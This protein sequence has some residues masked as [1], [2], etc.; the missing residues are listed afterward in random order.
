V[1]DRPGIATRQGK[2]LPGSAE[3]S[4]SYRAGVLGILV[5]AYTFNFID[6]TIIY[7]IGQA[8]K[9]D[10]ALSDTQLGLLGGL[11][12]ALF[13]TVLGIPIARLADRYNRVNI[14]A[15]SV[16]VWSLFTAGC[17]LAVN[18]MQLL[19]LRMGVGIG[20]AGL[21]PPAHSLISDYYAPERRGAALS[22]Y[23]LGIPVGLMFGAVAGGWLADNFSWRAAF[24]VVGLPG[25][26][27]ALIIKLFVR[28][29]PRGWSEPVAA[30][31][32]SQPPSQ[33]ITVVR[34][35]WRRPGIAHLVT[36]CTLVSMAAYGTSTYA[37]AYFIREFGV[38]YTAV[39]FV[40]GLVGGSSCAI[41]TLL[42][43]FLADRFGGR[44]P[45][46]YALVP[47]L[48]V[49]I[50]LP[51]YVLVYTSTN[52]TLAACLLFLPGIFHF[53]YSGPT[54]ALIQNSA[55]GNM[56]ATS[57]ALLL[58]AVNLVGL[59]IGPP[60]TGWLID[61]FSESQFHAVSLADFFRSCPGG[62]GA[63]SGGIEL[64][65]L[66]RASV[67]QGTQYGI[68]VTLTF[69]LW[70]ALHYLTSAAAIARQHDS[71]RRGRAAIPRD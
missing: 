47:G 30:A 25:L 39:G 36:G 14:I 29:P 54:F 71:G 27:V 68:L 64:D 46:W 65:R 53:M 69:Y 5:L 1:T 6:R 32:M 70:G 35:L 10:L 2:P 13:Y 50:A 21:S 22:T 37:P 59:G 48:G 18:Y 58:F 51:L 52:W 38:S 16:A 17:G 61:T 56:R 8:V 19:I 45:Y 7:T 67:A 55:P 24:V 57:A 33:L 60:L 26:F 63:A 12:F 66:C 9:E 41:G 31:S 3:F 28:E 49:L 20:E 23:A 62:L 43:G 42:G 11:A 4:E 40:F 44:K 15:V 34:H